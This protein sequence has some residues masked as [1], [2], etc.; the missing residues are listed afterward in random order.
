MRFLLFILELL[1]L[2]D[3]MIG[4]LTVATFLRQKFD[5][6]ER[7]C[8]ANPESIP[9]SS[10]VLSCVRGDAGVDDDNDD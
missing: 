7:T 2:L 3:D 6:E 1:T 8:F 10:G 4:F 9:I 5:D